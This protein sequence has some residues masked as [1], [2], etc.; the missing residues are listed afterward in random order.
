[1]KHGGFIKIDDYV[2]IPALACDNATMI[3]IG[4]FAHEF[5]HAF[6]LPDLYDIDQNSSGLGNWCLMASGSW[7]GDNHSPET[8]VRMSAWARQRLGWIDVETLSGDTA[9]FSLA[10]IQSSRHAAELLISPTQRYLISNL[11]KGGF[12][13]NL[14]TDGLQVWKINQKVLDAT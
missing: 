1:R 9:S 13:K 3:Q 4:V 7:G 14:P 11:V 8:P 10:D 12:D 2:V 5:G 6:D